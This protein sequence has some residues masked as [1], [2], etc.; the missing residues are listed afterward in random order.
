MIDGRGAIWHPNQVDSNQLCQYTFG[1][2]VVEPYDFSC[3]IRVGL[4]EF[5]PD[6]IVL[7][8]PGESL[9]GAIAHV[10]IREGFQ[11]LKNKYDFM[12]RQKSEN[13][14]LISMNRSEQASLVI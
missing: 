12:A 6:H 8:G 9:G 4:R 1:H 2:Q 10:L 14:I 7:L 3:S 11:G 5:N 13:P